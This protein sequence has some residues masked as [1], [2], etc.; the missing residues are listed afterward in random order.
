M[1]IDI[2]K[3]ILNDIGDISWH[4][5]T[6]RDD[7]SFENMKKL[8]NYLTQLENI[9]AT[10][11]IALEKHKDNSHLENYSKKDLRE[12][13][14]LIMSKHIIKEFTHTDFDEYWEKD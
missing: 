2:T 11:L 14:K 4:G 6:Y 5:D 3:Y 13:A 7:I 1:K 10:L 12:K 9:R 8:D